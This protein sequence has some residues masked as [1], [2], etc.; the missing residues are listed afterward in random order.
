MTME[1]ARQHF[2]YLPTGKRFCLDIAST[3]KLLGNALKTWPVEFNR[4]R[5]RGFI[6]QASDGT[7]I[8]LQGKRTALLQAFKFMEATMKGM[9][10]QL[11]ICPNVSVKWVNGF[12]P[13]FTSFSDD[14]SMDA[15]VGDLK[16]RI[17][18]FDNE[19]LSLAS[20]ALLERVS[21]YLNVIDER[22]E[23]VNSNNNSKASVT[24]FHQLVAALTGVYKT[25]A[26]DFSES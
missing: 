1:E 24:S 16:L 13:V 12:A 25:A 17:L 2:K 26:G 18:K 5:I 14:W 3:P 4:K 23:F 15:K 11:S 6:T 20:S 10:D 19:R 21:S 7:R 22:V 9:E 8:L